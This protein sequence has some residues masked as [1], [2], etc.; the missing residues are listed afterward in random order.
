MLKKRYITILSILIIFIAVILLRYSL[1]FSE[2]VKIHPEISKMLGYLNLDN[3]KIKKIS[4]IEKIK[5]IEISDVSVSQSEIDKYISDQLEMKSSFQADPSLKQVKENDCVNISIIKYE[6][7]KVIFSSDEEYLC[8]KHNDPSIVTQSLLGHLT[9]ETIEAT[10]RIDGHNYRYIITLKS[11]G[12]F[13]T[14]EFNDDF[15]NQFFNDSSAD[16]Y[17]DKLKKSLKNE[18]K[19][20][21]IMKAQ[22]E[23]LQEFINKCEFDLD[24]KQVTDYSIIIVNSYANEAFL[25]NKDLKSYYTENL[26]MSEKEFF[27]NCYKKGENY[28]KEMLVVGAI[29]EYKHYSVDDKKLLESFNLKMKPN[30]E[31]YT[32]ME[33][34]YFTK[35][36]TAPYIKNEE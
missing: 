36:V 1:K 12:K 33:Y 34:K 20:V 11:I 31:A 24:K 6:D 5:K 22:D 8:I 14:P 32:Y 3:C 2:K 23:I 35:A 18:H 19:N 4:D 26:K 16:D 15:V 7:D 9:G 27:D 25:Y 21:A 28:I 30:D 10:E 17:V 29:A 13:I